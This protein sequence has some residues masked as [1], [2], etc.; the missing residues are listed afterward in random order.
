[1]RLMLRD[2]GARHR[3]RVGK[4]LTCEAVTASTGTCMTSTVTS[5]S[6]LTTYPGRVTASKPKEISGGRYWD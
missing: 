3:D 6:M 1:M 2:T 5:S 4:F